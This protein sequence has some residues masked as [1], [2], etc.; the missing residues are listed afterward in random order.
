M[1]L[2]EIVLVSTILG[3][4]LKRIL[5][6]ERTPGIQFTLMNYKNEQYRVN[7]PVSLFLIYWF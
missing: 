3:E 2:I 1:E 7:L 5:K 4:R 6:D